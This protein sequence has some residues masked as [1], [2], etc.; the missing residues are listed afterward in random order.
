MTHHPN[1][2]KMLFFSS[3][4][5]QPIAASLGII[6]Q[7]I[8]HI[9][10]LTVQ[11]FQTIHCHP[12]WLRISIRFAVRRLFPQPASAWTDATRSAWMLQAS[13]GLQGLDV[14][15]QPWQ[16]HEAN[17]RQGFGR[18]SIM[19]TSQ[20]LKLQIETCNLS[21]IFL[22]RFTQSSNVQQSLAINCL[23]NRAFCLCVDHAYTFKLVVQSQS[24]PSAQPSCL[25]LQLLCFQPLLPQ[26]VLHFL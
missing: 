16:Q 9:G 19:S 4:C 25:I 17:N 10:Q 5:L 22:L 6:F 15:Q 11:P 12:S 26:L 7:G 3:W 18:A 8:D 23:Q 2:W 13:P 1:L 24:Q 20:P 14:L 21:H